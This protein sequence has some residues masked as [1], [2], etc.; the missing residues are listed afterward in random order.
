MKMIADGINLNIF[1]VID[2][3]KT[4][5]FGFTPFSP[6][7]GVGGHCIPVDPLFISWVSNKKKINSDFI[8]ISLRE[9]LEVTNW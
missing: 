6:G 3:A 1:D 9:N 2:A 8:K 7:P 5:P 4:K